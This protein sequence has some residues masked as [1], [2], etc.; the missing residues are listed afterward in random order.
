[1]MELRDTEWVSLLYKGQ[2]PLERSGASDVEVQ[3]AFP[4]FLQ[5]QSYRSPCAISAGYVKLRGLEM[6]AK[7]TEGAGHH[8]DQVLGSRLA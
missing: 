5:R 7:A 3:G 2:E 8:V 1:M 4:V 6:H